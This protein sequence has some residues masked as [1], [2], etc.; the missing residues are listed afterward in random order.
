[1][2]IEGE[3]EVSNSKGGFLPD[4]PLKPGPIWQWPP[5]PLAVFRAI[6]LYPGYILP[7]HLLFVLIAT[8]SHLYLTPGLDA[9][10]IEPLMS[11]AK[12]AARNVVFLVCF[13]G[14]FHLI[15]YRFKSQ[16]DAFKYNKSW[17]AVGNSKFLFRN[18]VH[19]NMFFAIVS[20]TPIWTG[21]EFASYWLMA[22][23]HVAVVSWQD[24][25]IYLIA[26]AAI[27]PIWTEC[28]FYFA[29]RLLHVPFLYDRVHYL[30]HKNINVG[31]WSGLAMHPVE[32]VAF[33]SGVLLFWILPSSPFHVLYYLTMTG[34]GPALGHQGF[35]RIKIGKSRHVSS[36]SYQHFLHHKYVTVNY[37][38]DRLF[39]PLDRWFGT[40]HDGSRESMN[41]L[42]RGKQTTA[43]KR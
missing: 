2:S 28:H 1:M 17:Q 32:H 4:L 10:R 5:R 23:G 31:P 41:S 43:R 26:L 20:G 42:K 40:F 3:A 19:D 8:C 30:H 34:L 14:S 12:L 15:L 37:A 39:L 38:S 22:N 29:H 35:D 11:A 33:F 27:T 9:V 18:Q 13:A 24:H 25:P 36:A 16:G 7:W 6:F 21:Y